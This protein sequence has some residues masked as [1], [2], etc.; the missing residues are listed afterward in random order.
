MSKSLRLL[1]LVAALSIPAGGVA[2]AQTVL[3]RGAA[4]G[5]TVEVVVNGTKTASTTATGQG[6]TSIVAKLPIGDPKK[7]EIDAHVF[8]DGC[9]ARHVVHIVDRNQQPP[10]RDEGCERRE[11]T[12]VFWVRQRSTLVLD[13][14]NPIPTLLLRQGE[15]DPTAVTRGRESPRGLVLFAGGG[16]GSYH[17]LLPEACGDVGS[18]EGKEGGGAWT[19]GADLWLTR[20]LAVEGA[21]V[22][23]HK[24]SFDG[25]GQNFRFT[26][27]MDAEI[28]TVSGKVGIP[29]GPVRL[30]GR[31]GAGF[32]RATR[33]TTQTNDPLNFD[34]DEGNPVTVPGG[35]QT[36][37]VQSEGWAYLFGGGIEGWVSPRFA[38][39]G[40]AS[41]YKLKGPAKTGTDIPLDGRVF[42]VVAGIRLKIF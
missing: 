26:Y 36:L 8:V 11:I 2:T 22:K 39:F 10:A 16:W 31:G 3:F 19:A 41:F 5:D 25:S 4:A 40:D 28:F 9:K 17:T 32:H 15:Y 18:C 12:G 13:V 37:E 1:V 21:Y 27:F 20:F 6:L 23:P 30:Y 35:T 38:L 14:S 42:T 7:P 33:S 29:A 24:A 34:D